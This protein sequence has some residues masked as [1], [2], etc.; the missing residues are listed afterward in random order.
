VLLVEGSSAIGSLMDSVLREAGHEVARARS[1][2][3]AL[4]AIERTAFGAIVC[5]LPLADG[6]GDTLL[7][8]AR[9]RDAATAIVI[10]SG[11]AAAPA[12]V[13]ALV[14]KPFTSADLREGLARAQAARSA[15]AAPVVEATPGAVT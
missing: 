3:E 15:I 14:R 9:A 6:R 12:E 2:P 13:D 5:E 1:I 11:D 7:A 4:A 8:A 10:V